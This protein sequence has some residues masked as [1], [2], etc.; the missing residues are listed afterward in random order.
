MTLAERCSS[1]KLTAINLGARDESSHCCT[2][3]SLARGLGIERL[4]GLSENRRRGTRR[5]R[6]LAE[7]LRNERS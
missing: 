3:Q 4:R 2:V 6:S 5:R 1:G 7:D